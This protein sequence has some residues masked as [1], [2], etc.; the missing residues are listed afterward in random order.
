[1]AVRTAGFAVKMSPVRRPLK[2]N[3]LQTRQDVSTADSIRF[4]YLS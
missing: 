3:D 4:E 2:I 1:M